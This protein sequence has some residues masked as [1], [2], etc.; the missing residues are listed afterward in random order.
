MP[1]Y[2]TWTAFAFFAAI[3]LPGLSGFV[4]EV[5][6]L[7]GAWKTW[8][9]FTALGASGIILGAGYMLWTLQRVF[10]GPVNEKYAGL[11]DIGPREA[12]T[13]LPLAILVLGVGIYPGPI[14]ELMTSSVGQ[15]LR[16]VTRDGAM[17]AGL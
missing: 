7:L 10:L 17:L 16:H 8:P 6:V 1:V 2:S 13:L 4:S 5:L 11:P 15:L 12:L 14:L 3:G 9:A